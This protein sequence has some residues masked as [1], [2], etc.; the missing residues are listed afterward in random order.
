MGGA[1]ARVGGGARPPEAFADPGGPTRWVSEQWSWEEDEI[2]L[3]VR[4]GT[5]DQ[6]QAG[7][8]YQLCPQPPES[9]SKPS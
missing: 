8:V 5:E 4:R 3:E 1:H 2:D 7:W 9:L 6:G